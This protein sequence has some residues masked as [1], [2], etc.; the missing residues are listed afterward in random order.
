M[1]GD[2]HVGVFGHIQAV[3]DGRRRGAP[4]FVQ[5]H[6]D[7]TG[8]DLLVQ[9]G[10]QAGVALAQKTQVHRKG[11]GRL[12]HAFHVPWPGR[13]GGGKGT[14]GR[15]GTAAEHGGHAG[16]QRFFDLLRADEVNVRVNAAGGD[17]HAFAADDLCPG[18][19]DDVHA[20]LHVRVAGFADAGDAAVFQTDVGLDDAP[21]VHDQRVGHDGVDSALRA[22]GLRLRHAVADG[23]AAAKLD[24]FAVAAGAQRVVS[25]DLDRQIGVGQ[26]QAVADRGAEHFSVSASSNGCHGSVSKKSECR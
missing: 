3:A 5:F 13:A 2:L 10:G 20:R 22:R 26:S 11:V 24:F 19:D 6:A 4:V 17:D 25:L 1:D 15:A 8:I 7:G 23:L 16:G 18:A 12:Q 14:G 9:R 21:V